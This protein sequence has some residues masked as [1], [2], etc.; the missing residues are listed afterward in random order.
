M[1]LQQ[2]KDGYFSYDQPNLFVDIYNS[3]VGSDRF[4]VCADYASYIEAQEKVDEAYRV[5]N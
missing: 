5:S 4:M 3:L 1:C 2:I